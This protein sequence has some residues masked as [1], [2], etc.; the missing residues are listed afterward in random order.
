M[1]P[2]RFMSRG[3]RVDESPDQA[4]SRHDLTKFRSLGVRDDNW[5]DLGGWARRESWPE[6]S[7]SPPIVRSSTQLANECTTGSCTERRPETAAADSR[8]A[9]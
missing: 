1:P 7:Q 3:T 9:C 8:P 5:T 6:L 4:L 2:W